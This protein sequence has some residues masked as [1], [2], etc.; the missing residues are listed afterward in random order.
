M[1]KVAKQYAVRTSEHRLAGIGPLPFYQGFDC[2]SEMGL[3]PL[4]IL[5]Y[6]DPG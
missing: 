5:A 2:A 3:A 4:V 1:S 6:L